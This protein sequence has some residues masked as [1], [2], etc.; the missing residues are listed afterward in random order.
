MAHCINFKHAD[1]K[2]FADSFSLGQREAAA[3]VAVWQEE[4]NIFDRFPNNV[5]FGT[6]IGQTSSTQDVNTRE[7]GFENEMDM[8]AEV[9]EN[10]KQYFPQYA[11]FDQSEI[12]A[13]VEMLATD[14]V[15]IKCNR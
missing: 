5:E 13:L 3:V 2:Q 10:F 14:E 11:Y 4:N 7:L 12:G 6:M 1:I 8:R 15:T 9:T